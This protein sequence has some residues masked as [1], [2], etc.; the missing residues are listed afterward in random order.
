MHAAANAIAEPQ[1]KRGDAPGPRAEAA[2]RRAGARLRTKKRGKPKNHESG[3]RGM[4][5]VRKKPAGRQ[6][7]QA[8]EAQLRMPAEASDCHP[9]SQY[10]R[11][12]RHAG[13]ADRV[14]ACRVPSRS[15]R[16]P[17]GASASQ[18]S[19]EGFNRFAGMK[20]DVEV[21]LRRRARCGEIQNRPH[22]S[23]HLRAR[24]SRRRRTLRGHHLRPR[25]GAG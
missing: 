19:L 4:R 9:P 2:E 3:P 1:A 24:L 8:K 21:R 18:R 7:A 13:P 16:R 23:P 15:H 20:L 12:R 5:N 10:Q 14:T 17:A 11:S 6:E 25:S 22:M